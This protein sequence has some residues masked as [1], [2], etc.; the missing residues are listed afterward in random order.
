L[1]SGLLARFIIVL[2]DLQRRIARACT[3]GLVPDN[4]WIALA[5]IFLARLALAFQFQSVGSV[6]PFLVHDFGIGFVQ[7]GT[8]VGLYLLPGAFIAIPGGLVGRRFGDKR[9][10]LVGLVLMIA[11][12]VAAGAAPTYGYMVAGR[13]LSG[14]GACFINVLVAKMIADWFANKE[15][16][17]AM[18]I[19]IIGWPVGIAAGQAVQAGI[20]EGYSWQSVLYLTSAVLALCLVAM[21]AL[22]RTPGGARRLSSEKQDLGGRELWMVCLA[23]AVWMIA[24]AAY[25]VVLTFGPTLLTE[26]GLSI[27]NAAFTVSLMSWISLAA[28][29]LGA[30][31]ATRYRIADLLMIAGLVG[32][33][34]AVTAIPFALDA[35]S[36]LF[37][38]VG[39][40]FSL[41]MPV[42]SSLPA[43][44]LA[45][46]NRALG[47]GVYYVWFYAGTPFLTAGGGWLKDR[48]GSAEFSVFYAAGLI[49]LSLGLVVWVRYQQTQFAEGRRL[50]GEAAPS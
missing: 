18:S 22:Y 8:L 23:G 35:A 36:W 4:R 30:Y 38:M 9:V 1:L 42:V 27:S 34:A 45:R 40:T 43:Q 21:A 41:A 2:H 13:L 3:E 15:L 32:S 28:L 20:A 12:G 49:V 6:A 39:F 10:V 17:F 37:V 14:V 33:A 19:N 5:L 31:L 11:G 44:L 16:V 7:V 47:F 50:S 25:L 24:N 29:P 48:F 26:H 46:Q